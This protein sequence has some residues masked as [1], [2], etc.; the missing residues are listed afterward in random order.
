MIRNYIKTALR[1]LQKYRTHAIINIMGLSL[2]IGGCLVLM[3]YLRH[4]LQFE[5]HWPDADRTYLVT[6]SAKPQGERTYSV[7]TPLTVSPVIRDQYAEAEVVTM[8]NN[9]QI[10]ELGF[11]RE[12]YP[13]TYRV[14]EGVMSID[15]LFG[16]VFPL[17][18]L[19]GSIG[20]MEG[21]QEGIMLSR[22]VATAMFGSPAAA[23]GE[24][25]TLDLETPVEVVAVF[26]DLPEATDFPFNALFS[27]E[28]RDMS[29]GHWGSVSSN[30]LTVVKL[31]PQA[32]V[33][34]FKEWLWELPGKHMDNNSEGKVLQ[35]TALG[36]IHHN[37]EVGGIYANPVDYTQVYALGAIAVILILIGCV[38]FV[39]LTTALAS[40]R[41]K[42]V[43]VRKVLGS[44]RK[45]LVIQFLVEAFVITSISLGVG[46][47]LAEL[48]LVNLEEHLGAALRLRDMPMGMLV[49]VLVGLLVGVSLV[50]GM[51]PALVMTRFKPIQ[52]LKEVHLRLKS[53]SLNIRRGLVVM[54]FVVSQIL[55]IAT[56]VVI[57]QVH[58]AKTK[59]MG[60]A[61]EARGYAYLPGRDVQTNLNLRDRVLRI[62]GVKMASL[63]QQGAASWDSYRTYMT[64]Q[65]QFME[66][67]LLRWDEYYMPLYDIQLAAGLPISST[68]DALSI[69]INETMAEQLGFATP[70]DALG[71]QLPIGK[72]NGTMATITG[73]VKDFQLSSVHEKIPPTVM[74]Y[75]PN[76]F[77]VLNFQME[78]ADIPRVLAAIGEEYQ[79]AYPGFTWDHNGIE[80]TLDHFYE[81][82]SRLGQL[83]QVFSGLAIL[84]GCLGLYG[85]ANFMVSQKRKEIG[86]RKVLGASIP[87]ILWLFSRE[88][89]RLV[90]LGFVVA[91]PVSLYLMRG[92][93]A[94]FAYQVPLHWYLF[95][96]GLVVSGL[97][98]M[99]AVGFRSFR[100]AR[101]N[102][103]RSL[104]YE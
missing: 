62:P 84:I 16:Q 28:Q 34:V 104:R 13:D 95:G 24:V 83:F 60:Y 20:G 75:I 90:L 4:Q 71:R 43:G 97:V 92:W 78:G 19:V 72:Y 7:G 51:Y 65:D 99:L 63:S 70:E 54:Q 25:V 93:L 82:E 26:E 89:L 3:L 80:E 68:G 29:H 5:A 27:H 102:P 77:G 38:N 61:V 45:H 53:G 33:S 42:E 100:A 101:A 10:G 98:A 55:I 67:E 1:S 35:A 47:V 69:L 79:K 36:E 46:L 39:N 87:H 57:A 18:Y 11:Q 2:G 58:Y 88:Y 23:M 85:L 14:E 6:T 41:A 17:Q 56:L 52:A 86:V 49:L 37:T 50:A 91:V 15:S 22:K 73:V 48:A 103:V 96:G 12:G 59:D 9:E 74:S 66:V 81:E 44:Q 8:L 76:D 94:Q 32:D 31:R 64:Y 21:R 30:H 40:Q